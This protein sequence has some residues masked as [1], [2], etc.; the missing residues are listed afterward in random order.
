MDLFAN[1]AYLVCTYRRLTD[2]LCQKVSEFCPWCRGSGFWSTLV[3][4]IHRCLTF[5]IDLDCKFRWSPTVANLPPSGRRCCISITSTQTRRLEYFSSF[6]VIRKYGM[7]IVPAF[8]IISPNNRPH[9]HIHGSLRKS[10]AYESIKGPS[11]FLQFLSSGANTEL[12]RWTIHS[13]FSSS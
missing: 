10:I 11:R 1:H 7:H 3:S 6:P 12:D 13:N 4:P 5:I 9:T 8:Q 2:I